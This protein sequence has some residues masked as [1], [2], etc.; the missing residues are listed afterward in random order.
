M[1]TLFHNLIII[2]FAI[3]RPYEIK[4]CCALFNVLK[5][6]DTP[7]HVYMSTVHTNTHGASLQNNYTPHACPWA[8][9]V[10]LRCVCGV[11]PFWL[12]IG[13]FGDSWGWHGWFMWGWVYPLIEEGMR[14]S[15]D[16]LYKTTSDKHTS[17]FISCTHST[18]RAVL[19]FCM[20]LFEKY[21]HLNIKVL[22]TDYLSLSL[23]CVNYCEKQP[24]S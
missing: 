19:T 4:H 5:V 8:L 16:C 15:A 20:L 11:S 3:I 23:D 17:W 14:Q 21:Q 13:R 9:R 22:C 2:F 18:I 12:L 1:F 7:H 24:S 6:S 10:N